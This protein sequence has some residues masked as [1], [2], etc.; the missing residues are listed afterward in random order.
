MYRTT[1]ND[2]LK[3]YIYFTSF[4][5]RTFSRQNKQKPMF[6]MKS[7]ARIETVS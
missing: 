2:Y 3:K 4:S 1:G 7:Y 6:S 5:I